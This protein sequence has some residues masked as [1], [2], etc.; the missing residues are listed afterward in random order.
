MPGL[1]HE[2]VVALIRSLPK[3]LRRPLVPI[4]ELATEVVA[5]LR[6][7]RGRLVDAV[8]RELE[9]ARGVRVAASTSTS[10]GC[11]RTCG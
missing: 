3:D 2:L 5:G 4:P 9:R 7:R 11:R 6:P 10:P 1:R 8:V